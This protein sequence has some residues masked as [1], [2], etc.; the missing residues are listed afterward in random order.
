MIIQ[1]QPKA[2]VIFPVHI[3]R[4]YAM[5]YHGDAISN[6]AHELA[7][8]TANTFFFFYCIRIIRIAFGDTDGLV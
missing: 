5:F 1:R 7:K 8:V 2:L 6:G 4:R 3:F